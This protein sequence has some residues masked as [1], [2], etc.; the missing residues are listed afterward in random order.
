MNQQV[1]CID[2]RCRRRGDPAMSRYDQDTKPSLD[3]LDEIWR[4]L[5]ETAPELDRLS[6]GRARWNL[7]CAGSLRPCQSALGVQA[8]CRHMHDNI[9]RRIKGAGDHSTTL[10][11]RNFVIATAI[12]VSI[13]MPGHASR[14]FGSL[15][16]K[17]TSNV[18]RRT[19]LV[20]AGGI[21]R[22]N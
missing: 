10:S 11:R 2:R 12:A 3:R 18:K 5:H 19:I 21:I 20:I 7:E 4:R 13:D 22:R 15:A 14:V 6:A 16:L 17:R 1:C 9:P 8:A